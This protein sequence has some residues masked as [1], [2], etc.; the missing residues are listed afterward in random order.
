MSSLPPT[1]PPSQPPF[2][3]RPPGEAP[4]VVDQ[5]S[6]TAIAGRPTSGKALRTGLL[7]GGG[8]LALALV[9]GGAWAA[10]SFFS[11]GAQPSE[12][13]PAG[14]LG[15]VSVDLDPSGGQKIEAVRTL[16]KFPKF[17]DVAGLDAD[18]DLRQSI[19]DIVQG[20]GAC[21]GLDF[22]QDIDPWLG[23]RAA[24]AAVPGTDGA[25]QPVVVVQ[26]TDA[27]EAA[28]GLTKLQACG[29]SDGARGA[30]DTS[31]KINGDWAVVAPTAELA[32][33]VSNDAATSSLADD[34]T[35]QKWTGETGAAGI[36]TLYAAPGAG[37]AIRTALGQSDSPL[38][39]EVSSKLDGFQ[40]VAATIRFSDGAFEM[41]AAGETPKV[42]TGLVGGASVADRV[43]DLPADTAAVLGLSLGDGWAQAALDQA[44]ASLPAGTSVDELLAE[45]EAATGLTLPKDLQ[46]LTGDGVVLA[47]GAG[48]DPET[49]A[50]SADPTDI[51][52]ALKLLG[53][54]DTIGPVLAKVTRSFP[55][56]GEFLGSTPDDD[57]VIVGPSA[58]YRAELAKPGT[59]GQ[60]EDYTSVVRESDSPAVL[61]VNINAFEATLE[62]FLSADD[63]VL[64]NL[65]PLSSIG[66]STSLDGDVSRLVLRVG[67]D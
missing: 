40:G 35:F 23:S 38:P 63:E 67:T 26:V 62:T 15:Y 51:P 17:T 58:D 30:R 11:T 14:T 42:V 1:P 12:A 59:L 7:A 65:E 39:P 29:E 22:D 4:E 57:S 24:L 66:M 41:E 25:P 8:V 47:V 10:M 60:S 50:N 5:S 13:L 61:Y 37:A 9:G 52:V 31:W 45:A 21:P 43:S 32:S 18:A 49:L 3:A 34:P 56:A 6:G 20:A 28:T 55:A 2:G 54:P 36:A 16:N 27:G 53:D 33:S 64:A 19:F 44:A 46:T 48:L